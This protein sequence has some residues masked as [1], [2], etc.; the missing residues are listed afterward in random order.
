MA[1]FVRRWHTFGLPTHL[2]LGGILLKYICPRLRLI[3]IHQINIGLISFTQLK[4]DQTVKDSELVSSFLIPA[5]KCCRRCQQLIVPNAKAN[6][7]EVLLQKLKL[8]IAQYTE[9][10]KNKISLAS[11]VQITS[12]GTLARSQHD[13]LSWGSEDEAP[14]TLSATQIFSPPEKPQEIPQSFGKV[15]SEC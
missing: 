1:D 12:K 10:L 2:S 9:Q 3:N 14:P 13:I 15:K 7:Q 5:E 6:T 8:S 11:P 4:R